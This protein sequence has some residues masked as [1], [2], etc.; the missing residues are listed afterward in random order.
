MSEPK[1]KRL[2]QTNR[3]TQEFPWLHLQLV[4]TSFRSSRRQAGRARA[5]SAAVSHLLSPW[6]AL[7]ESHLFFSLL[8]FL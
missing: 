5:A 7:H 6:I 3:Q 2:W 4:E 8:L 1:K